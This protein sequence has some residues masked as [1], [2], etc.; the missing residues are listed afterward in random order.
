[1]RARFLTEDGEKLGLSE[2]LKIAVAEPEKLFERIFAMNVALTT[3][4]D[5]MRSVVGYSAVMLYIFMNYV[6]TQLVD[7][8]CL[9]F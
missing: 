8:V 1:M 6:G 5:L 7:Q 3:V 4:V 9:G 2:K